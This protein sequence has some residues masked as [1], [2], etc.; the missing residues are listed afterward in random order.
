MMPAPAE[1][2]F[3]LVRRDVKP[4]NVTPPVETASAQRRM[5]KAKREAVLVAALEY[6]EQTSSH[7]PDPLGAGAR[8]RL[9]AKA[10]GS[11]CSEAGKIL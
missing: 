2:S 6:F 11:A 4:A 3:D 7:G 9:A 8:L 10:Y 1:S 5:W